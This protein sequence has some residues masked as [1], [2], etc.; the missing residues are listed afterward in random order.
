MSVREAAECLSP[1]LLLLLF[2]LDDAV[3]FIPILHE[4]WESNAASE[5]VSS[6]PCAEMKG[7]K[8]GCLLIAYLYWFPFGPQSLF[9][10]Q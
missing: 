7:K 10:P 1:V 5:E 2:V 8:H 9:H 3:T 4:N 6:G